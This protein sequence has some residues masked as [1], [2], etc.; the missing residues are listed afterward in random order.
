MAGLTAAL[1]L[2]QAGHETLVFE[3]SEFVASPTGG[4][5]LWPNAMKCLDSLGVG[6]RCREKAIPTAKTMCDW[7][8]RLITDV[9]ASLFE[10]HFGEPVWTI[11]RSELLIILKEALGRSR[12]RTGAECNGIE[13]RGKR[14]R[15][16]FKNHPDTWTDLVIGADGAR[17]TV[18]T[19]CFPAS[20]PLQYAGYATWQG[21]ALLDSS[22]FPHGAFEA[23]GRGKRFGASLMNRGKVAWFATENTA[24]GTQLETGFYRENLRHLFAGWVDPVNQII[25]KTP[26]NQ[27][28]RNEVYE[29]PRLKHWVSGRIALLGDAA[30]AAVPNLGQ[31][32]CQA[33]EDAVVLSWCLLKEECPEQALRRYQDRRQSRTRIVSKRSHLIGLLG[34]M[35]NPLLCGL[36]NTF[37]RWVPK[38][39]SLVPLRVIVNGKIGKIEKPFLHLGHF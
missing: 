7:R 4:L 26:I 22:D 34:Q 23:W 11:C 1:A 5:A 13:T 14:V 6:M 39:L 37:L 36:R 27:I 28:T 25:E 33:I 18:R 32:I 38:G 29:L 21:V 30:H 17:S 24:Q 19:H 8:G 2:E 20:P 3:K 16:R 9:N 15:L 31:G 12:I 35:A 10:R